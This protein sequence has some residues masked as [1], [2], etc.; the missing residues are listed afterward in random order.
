MV[1]LRQSLKTLCAL[2]VIVT[3]SACMK[4]G[5]NPV[6][7]KTEIVVPSVPPENLVCP[8][9]PRPPNP[10]TA[11]QRDVAAYLPDVIAVAEH[12]KRDLGVVRR[13]INSAADAAKKQNVE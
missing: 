2:C 9:I 13:I 6:E 11:T 4:P 7:V 1:K 10:D 8:E 5:A 3:I 12:C